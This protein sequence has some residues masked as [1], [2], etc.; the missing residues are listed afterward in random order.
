MAKV[1]VH[2]LAKEFSLENK[3]IIKILQQGGLSVKTHSSSVFA[4][5]ARNIIQKE[6]GP[7]ETPKPARK[8]IRI[9]KKRKAVEE[10]E[11]AV[12]SE[13]VSA[14]VSPEAADVSSEAA[15]VSSEAADVSSEAADVSS[16][17]ADV[18]SSPKVS[19]QASSETTP[20]STTEVAS[21]Q[22]QA[23]APQDEVQEGGSSQAEPALDTSSQ[24][25]EGAA[26]AA[27]AP[28]PAPQF[29]AVPA[30]QDGSVKKTGARVLRMID[31][32][33]LLERVPSRRLGASGGDASH[34]GGNKS[35]GQVTELKVV[36][37]PFG[38]GRE[39]VNVNRDKKGRSQGPKPKTGGGK[40]Q[41]QTMRER[42]MF[43][44][45]LRRKKSANRQ[46]AATSSPTPKASKRVVKMKE[47]IV[48]SELAK[49]L[50][51]KANE[52][53]R[54]LMGLDMM[55]NINA[56]VDFETAQLLA[57]DFEFTVE[58]IAFDEGSA[59]KE[60]QL[61][62][63]GDLVNGV[64]RPPVVTIMGHV[65]HG[66]T[67]LLDAIRKTKVASGEAGGITQ[68]IGAYS[69]Q[70]KG[71]GAITFLDTPGHAAFTEMR[72]RGANVTDIV[73]VVVAADDGVMPQTEEAIRHSQ[74][75]GVPII[76]VINKM[77]LPDANAEKVTQELT[78]FDLVPEAW[79]GETL[80]VEASA[81]KKTGID[82]LLDAIL[83]QAEV[84]ELKASETINARGTVL[85]AQLDKGR[86]PV[87]TILVQH[88]YLSRGDYVVLGEY[89]GRVRA[90]T[91]H[92]GKAVKKAGPADAVEVIGLEG[93]PNAGDPFNKADSMEL[94]R[95]VAEHR[96]AQRKS[97]AT[98]VNNKQSL[99]DLMRQM[100]GEKSAEFNVV[101]KADAQ[102]SVEAVRAAIEK[103]STDEVATKVL[104]GGVGGIKESDIM[105]ASASQGVVLGFN[106]RPD[107]N[108]RTIAQT[109]NVDIRTYSIIY[110]MLDDVRKGMEGL[111]SP[112]S[113]EKVMGRAEVRETFRISKI[114]VIAGCRVVEGKAS[115]AARVRV[116][117]DSIQ[118][119]DGRLSSL[120]HYK[121]D[122]REVD[123]GSECG[124]GVE[125]YQDIKA[126]DVLEF[127]EMEE[128]VRTLESS[129]R[130]QPSA[131]S[132]RA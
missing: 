63:S 32:D 84:L 126:T 108:A 40:R 107:T 113:Q 128:L 52:L 10:A 117:R 100:S 27:P 62:E 65:D 19:E 41:R 74:A 88:G 47:T 48:L 22:Q 21:E 54:K 55:V 112:I 119:F 29:P 93:V 6:L 16:E 98:V 101:L 12:A 123:S 124:I 87:A 70:V 118:V 83:L 85:E 46:V 94:A 75:A 23:L 36:T 79:G 99:D 3:A 42:S 97:K 130:S 50:G 34:T 120:K 37:D 73:V 86:G 11:I 49:Q 31:R 95:D 96:V 80:Y 115:R 78:Q 72:A 81:L 44:S 26:S 67:S 2:E 103:L 69:V 59:L 43:P 106:V 28:A 89:P 30:R 51:V 35:F 131:G 91:D 53:I 127:Y 111:L 14:D 76:V 9:K 33:K 64:P 58:N 82:G 109:E 66:K 132:A 60:V 38:G 68:H 77:D 121:E 61:E 102:G 39:M 20:A 8:G 57:T 13:S 104:Y 5:E 4:D 18:S 24:S 71:R 1:R 17:A 92:T 7:K 15:D 122:V 116:L 25:S 56:S 114:G 45:R 110:E 105:L 125:G 90:M 129:P